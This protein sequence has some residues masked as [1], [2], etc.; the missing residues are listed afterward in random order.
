M[1]IRLLSARLIAALALG[2]LLASLACSAARAADAAPAQPAK[3]DSAAAQPAKAEA[4][5]ASATA[6]PAKA[7]PASAAAAPAKAVSTPAQSAFA[8][9][10]KPVTFLKETV[11]TGAR[12]PRTYFESPQALSFLSHNQ[13]RDMAPGV[14]G[15]ALQQL[16]GVDN[17]KDSPWEQR[18]VLRGLSGQRVLVLMDGM[19][20]N[21]ARGNGP[22]PSLVDAEQ[23]ER[24]EIVRG[25]SSV[26]YGS[27]AIGG[28]IN[29]ITR[30]PLPASA[31]AEPRG[32]RGFAT[33]GGSSAEDM[34]GGH[35]ELRPH[36]DKLSAVVA[37]GWHDAKDF[38]SAAGKVHNSAYGDWNGLVG[39]NYEVSNRLDL[40]TGYQL[41][42]GNDIGI[43]GLSIQAPGAT[44]DFKFTYY[45]RDVAHLTLDEKYADNSWLS[46]TR[47]RAYYQ[48]E[49]RNFF[50]NQALDAS[51]YP[52]FGL[53]PNGS[54]SVITDQDRFFDLSTIGTQL[55]LTSKRAKGYLWTAG[56]D[57]ASDHT[58]GDNVRRR[59]YFY[60]GSAGQDSAGAVGSRVTQSVPD[61]T[62]SN[63]GTFFQNDW[64]LSPQ[65]TLSTGGRYTHYHTHTEAGPSAPGYAFTEQ[66]TRDDAF[67]G[68]VGVVYMP[69]RDLHVTANIAN[70]YRQPNAQDLYF[71]GAASVGYVVGNPLLRPEKSVS[72]DAG[73]RWGPGQFAV[74]GNLFVST[75]KDLIDAVQ[76]AP[77][78]EAQGQPTY[79]YT[80]ISDAIIAGG[81]V[82]GEMS[83]RRDWRAR[84]TMTGAAGNIT[85]AEAVQTLYG[86]TQD[87]AP[88]PGVP[89]FRGTAS[90]RWTEPQARGWVE[91]G[92]RY[93]WRTNRLPL[94]TPGVPQIDQFKKEWIVADLSMGWR[95]PTGQRIVLGCRNLTDRSYR[96]ALASLDEPGRSF[97]ASLSTDF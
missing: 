85:S 94:A 48:R 34:F 68:S 35:A 66:A 51:M 21:S 87:K 29:I 36:A 31:F 14:I 89:P 27:D 77:V 23:I 97:F 6:A 1:F 39:A 73:L 2:A 70:G 30:A 49:R 46:N 71:D 86:V 58:S 22:H 47:V 25:P 40:S 54:T 37:G 59:T 67:S 81:E 53:P 74:S 80:N 43:P 69:V 60:P 16:P 75:Y 57:F 61:G 65:W 64:F 72:Y 92:T 96:M 32:M 15:D 44:Q 13:I 5:P 9:T 24:V 63:L 95:T 62:F 42:R 78:P 88:L 19:P 12:Y 18:P 56:V 91:A 76:V 17:S 84:A 38:E 20:M 90:L 93:S 79:Q 7:A 55:Q 83:F 28:A 50:S 11:V 3:V 26:A 33:L 8:D 82:E 45:D 4:A 10:S 52:A 41:Y